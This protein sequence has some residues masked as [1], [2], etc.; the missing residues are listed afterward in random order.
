MKA[1]QFV[2]LASAIL[3]LLIGIY[4]KISDITTQGDYTSKYGDRW[5]HSTLSAGS[6]FFFSILFFVMWY[7]VLRE[8]PKRKK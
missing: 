4:F 7:V 2:V 8:K 6:L 3:F 5:Q 1:A